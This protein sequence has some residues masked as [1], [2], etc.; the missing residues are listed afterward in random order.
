MGPGH[1]WQVSSTVQSS[2][3]MLFNLIHFTASESP[4]ARVTDDL[5]PENV[6]STEVAISQTDMARNQCCA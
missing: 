4:G 2:E 5:L 1:C 6:V 3:V